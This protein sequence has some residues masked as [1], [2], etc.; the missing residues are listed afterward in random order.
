MD[1]AH[2]LPVTDQTFQDFR[3]EDFIESHMEYI[4]NNK[5]AGTRTVEPDVAEVYAGD[6]YGLLSYIGLQI[7]YHYVAM[8]VNGFSN[9]ADFDGS[10]MTILIPSTPYLDTLKAIYNTK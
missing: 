10:V 6:F 2:L 7:D 3:F 8:R 9:S 1:I 4:I 5:I